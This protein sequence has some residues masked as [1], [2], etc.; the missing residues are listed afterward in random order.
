MQQPPGWYPNPA[1]AAQLRWW[2]GNAWTDHT[3][4][5][6]GWSQPGWAVTPTP[7]R[8]IWPWIVFPL[9][10]VFVLLGVTAA[11]F[12]PRVVGAFKHP[13]DAANIYYGDLR[14]GRLPDASTST[15]RRLSGGS[16]SR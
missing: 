12:V 2:D 6:G 11:I 8:R 10:G 13:I 16:P 5:R 15:S 3:A 7:R 1:D 9:V 14:D 4:P